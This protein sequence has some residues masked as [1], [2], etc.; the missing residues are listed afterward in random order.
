MEF[1]RRRHQKYGATFI[2]RLFGQIFL[3]SCDPEVNRFILTQENVYFLNNLPPNAVRLL[4]NSISNQFG[5]IHKERRQLLYQA[6]QPRLL[7]N[8]I[9][10]INQITRQYLCDW[11]RQKELTWYPELQNYTL[12]VSCQ[13]L[14][15]LEKA[16]K[17]QLKSWFE[18][19]GL[20][21]FSFNPL[22]YKKASKARK[23]LLNQIEKIIV[24]R[25]EKKTDRSDALD[26]LLAYRDGEGNP[27][28]IEE[29]K[30][31][32]LNLLFAGYGSLASALTSFCLLVAQHPDVLAKLRA[33]Q[34]WLTQ[35]DAQYEP[36]CSLTSEQL[37]Q[38]TYLDC[39]I[40]E[41]M[42]LI[43]PIG[44]GFRKCIQDCTIKDLK[45][46]KNWQI[47]YSIPLLHENPQIYPNSQK[48]VPERFNETNAEFQKNSFSYLPFGGGLRECIGKEFARLEIKIFAAL[49][50]RQYHWE[51]QPHQNLQLQ[52]IPFP[53]P[54]DQLRV[55]FS[56]IG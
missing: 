30:E 14:I 24:Q 21:L 42:R 40:K 17:T 44:G 1:A 6:F 38:M 54:I 35:K 20:G 26:I 43:P 50:I 5:K 46:E 10:N 15:G 16:S 32:L 4:G 8:Y 12:D 56:K 52:T 51:L 39:V 23:E 18:A 53:R 33:E 34:Q 28:T 13:Y 37:R 25:P 45:I 29:V 11:E 31:Q 55:Y 9:E 48:F 47:I 41:V 22:A 3:Y 27:L 7:N 49:L 2:T 19:W 36:E